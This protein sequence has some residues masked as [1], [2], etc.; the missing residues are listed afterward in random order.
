MSRRVILACQ[1]KIVT[2]PVTK[3]LPLKKLS[4]SLTS[5]RKYLCIAASIREIGVIEPLIIHPQQGTEGTYILLDGHIRLHV[6]KEMGNTDV[7]CLVA[8]DDEAFTYN[9]KVNHLSPIQ[10]HFMILKAITNGVSEKRIAEALNVNI[11]S[12]RKKRDLLQGICSEAVELLKS[13]PARSE[14]IREM[15]RVKPIRQIEM[16]EMMKSFNNFTSGYAKCMVA[17]TSDELLVDAKK[18]KKAY[19]LSPEDLTRI[20][21]EMEGLNQ[22]FKAIEETHGKTVLDLTVVASYLKKLLE[23]TRVSR[24]LSSNY[25]EILAEFQNLVKTRT[26][27]EAAE[28][29]S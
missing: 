12:I 29:S 19:G 8:H 15:R 25:P 21:R 7:D 13:Y 14:T 5:G 4:P 22:D 17:A 9:H 26:L 18:S 20:E 16:A 3:L 10:E 11:A 2:I 28:A 6:L 27:A 24:Y 23:N 1:S